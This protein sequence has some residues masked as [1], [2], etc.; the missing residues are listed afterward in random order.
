MDTNLEIGVPPS[1]PKDL[2]WTL[3]AG[4]TINSFLNSPTAYNTFWKNL[5]I[6]SV[7]LLKVRSTTLNLSL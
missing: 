4:G 7:D 1:A 2:G 3:V 6:V 5:L